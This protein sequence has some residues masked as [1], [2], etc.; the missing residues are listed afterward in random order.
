MLEFV[1]KIVYGL[2]KAPLYN[3]LK[4]SNDIG[5][6]DMREL[7]NLLNEK[8][9]EL[10]NYEALRITE[11]YANKLS[12]NSCNKNMLFSMWMVDVYDSF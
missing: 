10:G 9:I 8:F 1:E 4:A 5:D 11:E 2:Q 12:I 7:F 3:L 6:F